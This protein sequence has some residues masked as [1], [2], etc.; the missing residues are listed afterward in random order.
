MYRTHDELAFCRKNGIDPDR[1]YTTNH[2]YAN[3]YTFLPVVAPK[4]TFKVG[5]RVTS[6][7]RPSGAREE[8]QATVTEVR[9]DE[10]ILI[11]FDRYVDGHSG[12]ANDGSQ[13]RWWVEAKDLTLVPAKIAKPTKTFSPNGQCGKLLTV[14]A[15]GRSITPL[16][17]FGT[18]GIYRLA[19]R[20][21]ELRSAGH[22]IN[23]EIRFDEMG[24]SY[25]RYTLK[26]RR[27]V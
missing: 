23:A 3:L 24:K 18:L 22:K 7:Y 12:G 19:A 16:E 14:L 10:D 4:P 13:R 27:F 9:T 20:I 15:S 17:A 5:D 6:A 26:S 25:A 8:D 1:S 11:E 21:H 2:H